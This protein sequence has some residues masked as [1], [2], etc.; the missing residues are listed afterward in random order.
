M[1][2]REELLLFQRIKTMILIILARKSILS[3]LYRPPGTLHAGGA[4]ILRSNIA[5]KYHKISD[6]LIH[7]CARSMV[8]F[9]VAETEVC[10]PEA[11][12]SA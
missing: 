7:T 6:S 2:D 11:A 4:K 10:G 1:T 9:T 5:A 8:I 3:P 12:P